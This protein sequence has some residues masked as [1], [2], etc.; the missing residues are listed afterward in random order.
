MRVL[1]HMGA[2]FSEISKGLDYHLEVSI[3]VS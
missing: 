2:T 3:S 1:D